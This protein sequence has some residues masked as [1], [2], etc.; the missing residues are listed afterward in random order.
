VKQRDPLVNG[1]SLLSIVGRG[2]D[3]HHQVRV[4][5]DLE[6]A[7]TYRADNQWNAIVGRFDFRDDG[8][9]EPCQLWKFIFHVWI[10]QEQ[11]FCLTRDP[12]ET[13]DLAK[14]RAF[15][16]VTSHFRQTLVQHFETEQRGSNW[17]KNGH[18]VAGRNTPTFATN[19][20]CKFKGDVPGNDEDFDVFGFQ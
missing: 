8:A 18:L 16:P 7:T 19:Y 2:G 12:W 15:V 3:R 20:P 13:Y 11:L 1:A 10:G 14:V 4:W 9:D 5:L 6:L 17:V